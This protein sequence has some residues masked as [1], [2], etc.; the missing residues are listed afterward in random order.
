MPLSPVNLSNAFSSL[1]TFLGTG[2]WNMDPAKLPPLERL[3]VRY[4]RIILLSVRGFMGD[5]CAL[6][7]SSLTFYSLLSI[8]PVA[9]MFFGIAKGFGF[10]SHL[11]KQLL[12]N[13]QAQEEVVRRVIVFAHSLLE[14]T[15]G[16]VIAGIG[17]ILLLWSVI[18]VLGYIE[19]SFNHIWKVER[20]RTF[21]RKFSDYISVMLISPIIVLMSGSLTVFITQMIM[22]MA[23]SRML[24]E[25][26]SPLL[27]MAVKYFPYCLIWVL[28]SF[29]YVVMPN[30][31]VTL[32]SGIF[33]GVL[34]GTAY[35]ALQ[36]FYIYFQVGLSKFNA[37]YGSFAA[38]PLFLIWLQ[39]SWLIV[40]AGAEISHAHQNAR[41][42]AY[43]PL[44]G[45]PSPYAAKLLALRVACPVIKAFANGNPPLTVAEIANR[46]SVPRRLVQ[47]AVDRLVESRIIIPVYGDAES[48]RC[49]QPA[50]DIAL[51]T[52]KGITDALESFGTADSPG[53][54]PQEYKVLE[55]TLEAFGRAAEKSGADIP[56]KDI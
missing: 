6:R 50:K 42:N 30:T 49:F 29:I 38:L 25:V 31:R 3:S 19:T 55:D 20:S 10:E 4:L 51:I 46:L 34:A 5:D 56:I 18:K 44:N 27:I 22:P 37:I 52:V 1:R 15:K 53:K 36:L 35:Q 54:M 33:A 43:A 16:G 9:A 12:E 28:F 26:F 47:G 32:K 48:E 41:D 14:N 21:V 24:P 8:V 45:K 13:F 7:A 23:R 11:E 17:V 2:I 39:L 40:L